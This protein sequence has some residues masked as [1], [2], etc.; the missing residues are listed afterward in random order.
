MPPS[1]VL[2]AILLLAALALTFAGCGGYSPSGGGVAARRVV[3]ILPVEYQGSQSSHR[4]LAPATAAALAEQVRGAAVASVA[5]VRDANE[6]A[7]RA[8]TEVLRPVLS[9]TD[10]ETTLTIYREFPSTRR[11]EVLSQLHSSN[12][13]QHLAQLRQTLESIGL[14]GS[15]FSTTNPDAFRAFGLALAAP[16]RQEALDLLRQALQADPQ[17]T[18]ASLRLATSVARSGDP[19]AA[20]TEL[21]RLMEALPPER[22]L[23]RGLAQLELAGL[24]ADRPAVVQALETIVEAVPADAEARFQLAQA[25]MQ[26]RRYQDAATHFATL[27]QADPA[28][29]NYWNQAAYAFAYASNQAEANRMLDG[30]RR[31]APNDANTD[32]TAGDVAFFFSRFADAAAHYASAADRS[33]QAYGFSRFKAAWALLFAAELKQADET[34]ETYLESIRPNSE[35][36]ALFRRA[37]WDYLRGRREQARTAAEAIRRQDSVYGPTFAG[38]AAS[39]LYIWDVAYRG[40]E[41]IDFQSGAGPRYG[42]QVHGVVAAL[43][44]VARPGISPAQRAETVAR[45]VPPQWQST[46]IAVATHLAALREQRLSPDALAAFQIAD[47]TTPENRALVTH[48]LLGWALTQMGQQPQAL[49]VFARRVPPLQDDDGLLWPLVL[50]AA[51]GWEQQAARAAAKPS[52]LEKLDSLVNVLPGPTAP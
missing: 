25:L 27:T 8:A 9:A 44:Q 2:S 12:L 6:A 4:W 16:S 47:A 20:E 33:P 19:I 29:P 17:F 40:P 24:R 34:M 14:A 38:L 45:F 30:Y 49:D 43:F 32:D 36:L 48:A 11:V 37:Q 22:S 39:Q 23:E 13:Q 5:V 18:G 51:L 35:A 50:P 3:A 10:A 42:L 52:T 26:A 7:A 41:T 21:Y 31:A 1:R 15:R 46:V 28:F